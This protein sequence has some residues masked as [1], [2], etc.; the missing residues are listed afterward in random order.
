[1]LQIR[2][3]SRE[4]SDRLLRRFNRSVQQSGILSLSK[5]KKYCKRKPSK[6]VRRQQAQREARKWI[7]EEIRSKGVGN[8]SI[9][10][11]REKTDL[12]Y[13]SMAD[14]ANLNDKKDPAKYASLARDAKEYKPMRD[15]IAHTALLTDLAKRKLTTVYENIKGRIKTLL[16]GGN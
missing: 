15:A 14:L 6:K 11:R 16:S 1:M 7:Q 13:L 3:K 8:I 12:N 10:I 4:K 9:N 2:K 5:K